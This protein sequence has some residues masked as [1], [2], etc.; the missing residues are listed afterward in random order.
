MAP[1]P[2]R[3]TS[4]FH[5]YKHEES[6]PPGSQRLHEKLLR[7]WLRLPSVSPSNRAQKWWLSPTHGMHNELS[8]RLKWLDIPVQ[9]SRLLL[10]KGEIEL[11]E[12]SSSHQGP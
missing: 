11:C 8:L 9:C 2:D 4:R 6:A 7:A 10:T 12:S 1:G 5:R 3:A